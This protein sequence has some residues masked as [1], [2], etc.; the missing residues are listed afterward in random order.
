MKIK[1]QI[2]FREYRKLLFSLTYRK[3]IMKVI[4][5]FAFVMLVWILGYYLHF[6][7]VPKPQIYQYITLSL[8]TVVQ[9]ITIYWTIKRNYDSSNHLREQLEIELSQTEIKVQGES[10][11][12]EIK[13][14]KIFKIDEEPNWF[15]MYQNNLSAIIIPRKEFSSTQLAEFKTI[16]S[17]IPNVPIHLKKK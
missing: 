3:P 8:I 15:L 10:F 1:T 5:C 12:T 13:W 16:L 11:Y 6:L 17:A 2:S 9:P 4:L 14:E 7:P